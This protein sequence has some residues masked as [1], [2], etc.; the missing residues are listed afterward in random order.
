MPQMPSFS[1]HLLGGFVGFSPF[2]GCYCASAGGG[3]KIGF[4]ADFKVTNHNI[5]PT[6]ARGQRRS[7]AL[8]RGPRRACACPLVWVSGDVMSPSGAVG[9][10]R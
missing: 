8:R 5:S 3:N 1:C 4:N 2:T 7:R 10:Q 6:L 9:D